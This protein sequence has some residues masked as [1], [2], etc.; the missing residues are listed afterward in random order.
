M[1]DGLSVQLLKPEK[2]LTV[3]MDIDDLCSAIVDGAFAQVQV[4]R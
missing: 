2:H 4:V 3:L 1:S